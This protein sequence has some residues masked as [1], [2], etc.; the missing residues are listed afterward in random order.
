MARLKISLQDNLTSWKVYK[1][2][3]TFVQKKDYK[4]GF[5]YLYN[6]LSFNDLECF[7]N[8]P[9]IIHKSLFVHFERLA[10]KSHYKKNPKRVQDEIILR[11]GKSIT[12]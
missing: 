11:D 4:S 5:K 6:D 9:K 3:R 2:L 1:K 8:S 10:P 7:I 12:L